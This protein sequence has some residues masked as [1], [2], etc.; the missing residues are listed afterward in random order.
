MCKGVLKL[1]LKAHSCVDPDAITLRIHRT[2]SGQ[3]DGLILVGDEEIGSIAACD[4]PQ[5]VE[6]A[7]RETGLF[8]DHVEFEAE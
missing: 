7:A 2:S 6:D 1:P 8:P 3:W 4:T 5:A